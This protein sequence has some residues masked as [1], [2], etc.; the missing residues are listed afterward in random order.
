MTGRFSWPARARTRVRSSTNPIRTSAIPSRPPLLFCSSRAAVE[1]SGFDR[2]R[3]DQHPDPALHAHAL[4]FRHTDRL[5]ATEAP[6]D[7]C[8]QLAQRSPHL[9]P[10][11]DWGQFDPNGTLSPAHF[12]DSDRGTSIDPTIQRTR[13]SMR[14]GRRQPGLSSIRRSL[15]VPESRTVSTPCCNAAA[16]I[17]SVLQK[18]RGRNAATAEIPMTSRVQAVAGPAAAVAELGSEGPVGITRQ[19]ESVAR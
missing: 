13:G 17:S 1:L 7:P 11:P 3:G 12:G 10:T 2:T 15:R 19:P 4:G 14:R 9:S 18:D 8:P 6:P 16:S 5:G